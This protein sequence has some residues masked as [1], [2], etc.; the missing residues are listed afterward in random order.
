M[1]ERE[2]FIK[3]STEKGGAKIEEAAIFQKT[4]VYTCKTKG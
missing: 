2:N 4:D 1:V 3:I